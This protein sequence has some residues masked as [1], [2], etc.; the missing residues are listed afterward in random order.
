[1]KNLRQKL[2]NMFSRSNEKNVENAGLEIAFAQKYSMVESPYCAAIHALLKK[3]YFDA[4]AHTDKDDRMS[5]ENA[6]YCV[7]TKRM[8]KR[9]Y[10]GDS[11]VYL[12]GLLN[13]VDSGK[14]EFSQVCYDNEYAAA[15]FMN[16]KMGLTLLYSEAV[17]QMK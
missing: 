7:A 8:C 12:S 11:Q 6:L 5:V 3:I 9:Q 16:L 15:V 10:D 2:K 17:N 1:M 4:Q 13:D 14:D